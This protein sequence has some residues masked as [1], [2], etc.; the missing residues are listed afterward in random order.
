M[1]SSSNL[2]LDWEVCLAGGARFNFHR[3]RVALNK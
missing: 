2:K 3:P 1:M